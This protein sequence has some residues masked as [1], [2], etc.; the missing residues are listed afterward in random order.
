MTVDQA[1]ANAWHVFLDVRE[2]WLKNGLGR[3]ATKE[4]AEQCAANAFMHALRR[5]GY[6]LTPVK[7]EDECLKR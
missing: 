3:G 5:N 6:E 1:V 4:Y 2:M 7:Q